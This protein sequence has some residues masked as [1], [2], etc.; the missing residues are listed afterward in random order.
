ML[1]QI[2]R[3]THS[4][5]RAGPEAR[6][7]AVY[8][9]PSKLETSDRLAARSACESGLEGVACVDDAA[10]ATILYCRL[11]N[12]SRITYTRAAAYALLRFLAYMQE[13]DGRFVNFIVDW[14]G[15]RNCVG[16]TSHSG[17]G[18]WQAR[19][20]HALACA[21]GTFGES[22]WDVRFQ[23]AVAWLDA[24]TPYLDVRAVGVL[25]ALE[26]W[27]AT[28][29]STSAARALA[30]SEEIAN[31]SSNGSL[32]NAPRIQ[33]I[34]LWGHLQESALAHVGA[35]F[36]RS[37]L[38]DIARTSTDFLLMP[39]IDAGFPFTQVL[40][41]D[42]S[43]TI[44]GLAAVGTATSDERY[45]SA[46]ERGRDWFRGRNIAAQPVYDADRGLVF[47]GIDSGRVSRNSGAESNIEGALALFL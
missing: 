12:Q 23:R 21:V 14:T 20:T 31:Y 26:H 17:G 37:D 11:W 16:S 36:G 38:L 15:E 30:W 46:A 29:S 1:R 47:D 3:L 9:E 2:A 42:V 40:P 35:A 22:E 18:P 19:A 7:I 43:C 6:A 24:P 44:A 39:A 27:R 4:V 28:G 10:R 8:A 5:S 13:P 34:H 25:A 32:L 45:T 41:F 33:Q